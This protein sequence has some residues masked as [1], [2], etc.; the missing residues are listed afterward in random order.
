[1]KRNADFRN[2]LGQ[3]DEYF[4]QSVIDTLNELDRE[5]EKKKR[6]S[7]RPVFRTVCAC[8]ALLVVICGAVP[9]LRTNAWNALT[10]SPPDS[11]NPT[12]EVFTPAEEP[13][14]VETELVTIIFQPAKTDGTGIF[15]D[16]E[17]RPKSGKILPLTFDI[18]PHEFSPEE[19]GKTPDYPEQNIYQWA[20]EHGYE[21]ILAVYFTSPNEKIPV[22][23][24]ARPSM[25][26]FSNA[27]S[28]QEDGS[29]KGI[30]AGPAV[31]GA[32]EYELYW[33]VAP[34]DMTQT[35]SQLVDGMWLVPL[36]YGR[37]AE[38]TIPFTVSDEHEE[39]ALLAVYVPELLSGPDPDTTVSLFRSSLCDYVLFQSTNETFTGF[40]AIIPEPCGGPDSPSDVYYGLHVPYIQQA[41]KQGD[42][43]SLLASWASPEDPPD[44]ITL[45]LYHLDGSGEPM[46]I[47]V[48]RNP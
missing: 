11:I 38:G 33:H 21:Q 30:V 31:P 39:A 27:F 14:T 20:T 5:A 3:P 23:S 48:F 37:T 34:Y 13:R 8:A 6:P 19:I 28:L 46:E 15:M 40:S 26:S 25:N 7:A 10:A 42:A 9:A 2:A 32:Q 17:V 47:T 36:D 29:L 4:R 1:M 35:S 18:H 12:P 22:A 44:S 43:L 45:H 16:V 41:I 24:A